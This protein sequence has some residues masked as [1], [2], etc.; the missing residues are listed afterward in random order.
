MAKNDT[1][2]ELARVLYMS[3]LSQEEILQKVE[4]SR[5]TLSRWINTLGWKEMK[6]A[7]SITRPELVNKLLSSSTPCSTRRTSRETRICW[8]AW[9]TS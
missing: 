7:R 8:P 2:Q 6:A 4:V 3:G 5:Q 9:A 1:K